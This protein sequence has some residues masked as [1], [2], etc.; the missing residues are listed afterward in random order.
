MFSCGRGNPGFHKS[1]VFS[2]PVRHSLWECDSLEAQRKAEKGLNQGF[3]AFVI[4]DPD[5]ESSIKSDINFHS[6]GRLN[7]LCPA[8]P[9][10]PVDPV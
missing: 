8:D 9:V 6:E 3:T 10:N 4:P 5:P 7:S 1:D 2:P